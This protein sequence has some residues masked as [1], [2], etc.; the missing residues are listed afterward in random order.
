M[1]MMLAAMEKGID[2]CPMEGFVP[3]QVSKILDLP[4]HIIPTLII[5]LGYKNM[6]QPVKTRFELADVVKE[7][8]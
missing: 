3:D 5:P 6:E 8:K 1:T 2:S 7:I 4:A